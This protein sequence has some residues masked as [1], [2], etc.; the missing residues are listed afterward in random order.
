M[1]FSRPLARSIKMKATWQDELQDYREE[2]RLILKNLHILDQRKIKEG[3][4]VSISTYHEFQDNLVKLKQ[5][6][7]AI[8]LILSRH[9]DAA[10][11]SERFPFEESPYSTLDPSLYSET[12]DFHYEG[13]SKKS[14]S[15][16]KLRNIIS[17]K[18][19]FVP[20]MAVVVLVLGLLIFRNSPADTSNKTVAI[21][22][23]YYH[24][25]DAPISLFHNVY[26]DKNPFIARFEIARPVKAAQ[27]SLT[28][29]DIDPNEKQ[30][31]TIVTINGNF[32]CYLNSFVQEENFRPETIVIPL[33]S[34]F[35]VIGTNE[36]KIEVQPTSIEYGQPNLDDFEFWDLKLFIK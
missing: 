29:S 15:T 36:I 21:Q 22:L 28:V 34:D 19:F 2:R 4:R 3:K 5:V 12:P 27:L 11:K 6:E 20:V 9:T 1:S 33:N 31:P 24:L 32:V 10:L 25:G 7:E 18:L 16:N 13:G 8:K 14:F 26:P 17:N 35:F 23:G 30:S